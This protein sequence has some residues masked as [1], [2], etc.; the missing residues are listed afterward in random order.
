MKQHYE[1]FSK[2]DANFVPLTPL[3]FITRTALGVCS[4][5]MNIGVGSD[6]G[7]VVN[8]TASSVMVIILRL[9]SFEV[10]ASK[11]HRSF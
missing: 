9:P 10:D 4:G 11:V 6:T 3:S 8:S 1:A 2:N 7:L 5:L